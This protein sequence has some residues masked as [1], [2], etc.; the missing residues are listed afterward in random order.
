MSSNR[1]PF[2]GASGSARVL[3]AVYGILT[4]AAT[5]RS[6]VQIIGRF[7]E[8]PLAYTLSALAALVYGLATVALIAPGRIWFRVAATTIAF[9][10]AGVL[11]IGA[12]STLRPDL[13]PAD[14]VWSG[15]GRGYGYIPLVLPL[16]GIAW[17]ET[18]HRQ[19][20][21]RTQ[22]QRT[23]TRNADARHH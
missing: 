13:F 12:V 10:L 19:A 16:L 15:F 20:Q 11:L 18:Q 22:A 3:V 14:T 17:L 1:Q 9:E 4:L 5:G 2:G 6:A 23:E 7:H 8:A 21:R